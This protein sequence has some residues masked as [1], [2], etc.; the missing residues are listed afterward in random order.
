MKHAHVPKG[1]LAILGM[2]MFILDGKT[3]LNG[4][5]EGIELCLKTVI[6]SLFPFFIF[7]FL[8]VD[9]FLGTTFPF[10]KVLRRIIPIPKGS[11]SILI[12]GILGGYPT[13]AQ[14]ISSAYKSNQLSLEAAQ[15]ML[16][17]CNNAGPAFVFG[18]LSSVFPSRWTPWVLWLIHVTSAL[19]VS[20][21]FPVEQV[22]PIYISGKQK[23]SLSSALHSAIRSIAS[24]CGWVILFR[25]ILAFCQRWF[26]WIFP[27]ELQVLF[28]GI[29]ELS[30]ACCLLPLIE[31][32]NLRFLLC[33]GMLAFGGLC[34]TMQ[35]I[36]VAEG[37][38]VHHYFL[39][40]LLQTLFSLALSYVF[41]Y[42][43]IPV[44]VILFPVSF[45][46]FRNIRK[47]SSFQRILGV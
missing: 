21:F 25:T 12:C 10:S 1:L 27:A 40:K 47:K 17:F 38:S 4:A 44:C 42:L 28:T 29:L 5:Q 30:N 2:L 20:Q 11:E 23:P 32:L 16:A 26:F 31:D 46:L 36:S 13:G 45:I 34:I 8:A 24:V 3:A 35:T 15:K 9:S 19:F 37:I 41:L 33:S 7:S 14:C 18:I 6:P 43:S 22:S 39:G